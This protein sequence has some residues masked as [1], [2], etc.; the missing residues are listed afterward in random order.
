[1]DVKDGVQVTVV[2]RKIADR[3]VTTYDMST[4]DLGWVCRIPILADTSYN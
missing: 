2:F 1:M 3:C 4:H